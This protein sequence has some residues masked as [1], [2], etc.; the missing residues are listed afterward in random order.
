MI[1]HFLTAADNPVIK[2]KTITILL[3]FLTIH[4]AYCVELAPPSNIKIIYAEKSLGI[5]WDTTP[6]AIGYNIYT[7]S[8]PQTLKKKKRKVN[9]KL[10]TSG[11]HFTYL[12]HFENK[13]KVRKIKGYKHFITVTSVF[14]N[15]GKERESGFSPLKD[16][17][18]FTGYGPVLTKK[19]VQSII[20][21]KQKT[22]VLPVIKYSNGKDAFLKFMAG[23]GKK[24]YTI[25]KE[26]I[27]FREKGGCAPVSTV[28]VKLLQHYGLHAFRIDGNFIREFHT[29]V[30]INIDKV[31]YVL[32][33]TADQFVPGAISVMLPRDFC[34]LDENGRLSESGTPVYNIAKVYAA[35]QVELSDDTSAVLYRE[36][37]NDII[38][39]HK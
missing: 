7:S 18:Y 17:C 39:Q 31:E 4:T 25:I 24:L 22:P 32:D 11:T 16:N 10:I 37:Y 34:F 20:Q 15:N 9:T 3:F 33:F 5:S 19:A 21:E 8:T 35:D 6:G 2:F 27:D 28:L 30:L 1:S 29:F 13:K 36:M 12:W 14:K 23:P 38:T 26:K